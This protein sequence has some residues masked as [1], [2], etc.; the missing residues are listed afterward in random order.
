M[1]STKNEQQGETN[2]L[3]QKRE[4]FRAEI[5]KRNNEDVFRQKRNQLT[6]SINVQL[7]AATV[8]AEFD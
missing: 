4:E 8:L 5:R 7:D 3:R 6:P 1:F 2:I